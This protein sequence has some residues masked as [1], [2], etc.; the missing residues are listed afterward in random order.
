[1]N[2]TETK[3]GRTLT[4]Q[5]VRF[6]V[7]G[8]PFEITGLTLGTIIRMSTISAGFAHI[9]GNQAVVPAM[10][11]NSG[12]MK[13]LCRLLAI[14]IT[15]ARPA[16]WNLLARWKEWRL[17][18]FLLWHLNAGEIF[19]LTSVLVKQMNTEAFFFTMQLISGANI[20]RSTKAAGEEKPSGEAL[21]E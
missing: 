21:P 2:T 15:N 6:S 5:P 13:P 12:N 1:M 7:N 14:G 10:L 8:K 3:A 11:G 17:S 19:Q 18:Y 4:E 16:W 20:L 9:D